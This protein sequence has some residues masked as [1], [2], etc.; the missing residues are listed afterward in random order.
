MKRESFLKI[1][2]CPRCKS[3]EVG[4]IFTARNLFGIIPKMR[5]KK[6]GFKSAT[7][8]ILVINKKKLAKA[9]KLVSKNNKKNG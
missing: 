3:K 6:C 1:Y 4:Y 9:N 2:F 7:F 8:P 5:C